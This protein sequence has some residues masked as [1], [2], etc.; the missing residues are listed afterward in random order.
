MYSELDKNEDKI[1]HFAGI[2]NL[3]KQDGA[4][5]VQWVYSEHDFPNRITEAII[6][7]SNIAG[8]PICYTTTITSSSDPDSIKFK[9]FGK[10][11]IDYILSVHELGFDDIQLL[12]KNDYFCF[13]KI[14]N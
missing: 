4:S 11:K 9:R 1:N 7:I 12:T 5:I 10:L 3:V 14:I 6:P 2:T 8:Y 13:Y